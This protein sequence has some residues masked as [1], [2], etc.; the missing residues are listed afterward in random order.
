[1]KKLVEVFVFFHINNGVAFKK[2][3]KTLAP[4]ITTTTQLLQVSTQPITAINV[5]FSSTGLAALGVT[6]TLNDSLYTSGQFADAFNLSDTGT[7]N[8]VPAFKGTFVHGVFL[9]ASDTL[10]S[11]NSELY[12]IQTLFGPSMITLHILQGQVRP[13]NQAGHERESPA[14]P[15]RQCK[16]ALLTFLQ[17]SDSWTALVSQQS[18]VSPRTPRQARF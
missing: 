17:I 13:G 16:T 15:A 3:L 18:L 10:G 5:A 14:E 4:Q 8:W 2:S 9:L 1:M 11:I 12:S 6:D 7:T